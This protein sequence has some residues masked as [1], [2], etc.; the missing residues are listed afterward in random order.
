ML[1]SCQDELESMDEAGITAFEQRWQQ[2]FQREG[3]DSTVVVNSVPTQNDPIANEQN[4]S[5]Q[6]YINLLQ[7][8]NR[9]TNQL[10]GVKTIYSQRWEI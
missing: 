9:V 8:I 2:A 1:I 4:T 3:L 5:I 6:P 7:E 10:T